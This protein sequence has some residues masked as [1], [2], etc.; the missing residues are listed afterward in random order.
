MKKTQSTYS[1]FGAISATM[2]RNKKKRAKNN[3]KN[4]VQSIRPRLT[5]TTRP[6][7]SYH[8]STSNRTIR[9]TFYTTIIHFKPLL[10]F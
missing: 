2:T 7:D 1:L 4:S 5:S 9:K 3:K 8:D 10:L 6:L